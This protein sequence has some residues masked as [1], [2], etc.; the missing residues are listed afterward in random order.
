MRVV[1]SVMM[2][3]VCGLK[4]VESGMTCVECELW[5]VETDID[6]EGDRLWEV[7]LTLL[8]KEVGYGNEAGMMSDSATD[9]PHS[10]H[11]ARLNTQ[12]PH[13]THITPHSFV[14]NRPHLF[15]SSIVPPFL[16]CFSL[17]AGKTVEF[18]TGLN[19]LLLIF[20][21]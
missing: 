8:V 20:S 11:N 7:S 9:N 18:S 15:R 16:T 17:D 3:V 19:D 1:E 2:C 12:N 4:V 5:V 10:T 21:F 14:H 13:L 6:G